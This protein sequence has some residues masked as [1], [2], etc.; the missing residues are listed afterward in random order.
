MAFL[1][2]YQL[3]NYE[4]DPKLR[5]IYVQS[6]ERAWQSEREISS[7]PREAEAFSL[8][9]TKRSAGGKKSRWIK[10]RGL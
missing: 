9:S 8:T 6:L 2:Y 5:E 1:S 7:T 3:L 10:S 4:T